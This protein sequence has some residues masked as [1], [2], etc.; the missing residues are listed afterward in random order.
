MKN[1]KT[2]TI[3]RLA[4]LIAIIAIMSFTPLGYI[5]T[6]GLEISFLMIP[7]AIGAVTIGPWGGLVL[8][9]VFGITSFIQCFGM[10]AFGTTLFGISPLGTF[11]VCFVSRALA[12]LLSGLIYKWLSKPWKPLPATIL[13][14]LAAPVFNTVFFMGTLVLFFYNTEYIR[15][16][17]EALGTS[18]PLAF[19]A[20][21][22]GIQG[23][24]EAVVCTVV[25]V[26]ICMAIAKY[27]K[28]STA[29]G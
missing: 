23:V 7:V 16:I 21:F 25:S 13:G 15:G 6:A 3:T 11:V 20:A 1:K 28:N 12:G 10:S 4:V 22:V 17:A 19:I 18:N 14:C 8:G 9:C 5:R 26:P 29:G 2:R 24:V 27:S